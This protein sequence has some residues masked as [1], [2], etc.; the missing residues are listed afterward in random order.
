VNFNMT[1]D[2][3]HVIFKMD[4]PEEQEVQHMRADIESGK[5][6][7]D[8]FRHGNVCQR[9]IDANYVRHAH[10]RAAIPNGPQNVWAMIEGKPGRGIQ[11]PFVRPK[12]GEWHSEWD[13]EKLEPWK[14]VVRQLL[15]HHASDPDSKLATISTE[16]IPWPD[17]GAG[18]KYSLFEHSIA[19]AEW[20]RAEWKKAQEKTAH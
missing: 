14:E 7:L 2:H 8:P 3:S 16:F 19:C 1:L 6:E 9:W 12:S 20:I 5:L 11:Y 10:A 4:N 18:A 15:K 13:A 17:Y